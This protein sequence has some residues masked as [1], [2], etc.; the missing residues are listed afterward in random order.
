MASR[1]FSPAELEWL[2]RE[3]PRNPVKDTLRRFNQAFGR[4]LKQG[5]L[6]N[7]RR[8]YGF[9]PVMTSRPYTAR[10]LAW[11][12]REYPRHPVRETLRQ[13]NE[14]FGR[15]LNYGQ[16]TDL[17]RRHGFEQP[18]RGMAI[19][20]PEEQ[21]WMREHLAS[22]PRQEIRERFAAAF[23]RTL[24]LEQLTYIARR[25]RIL[26][27]PHPGKF[28]PVPMYSERW[29][30]QRNGPVLHIKVPLDPAVQSGRKN[31]R[32][33]EYE[34]VRKAVWV[35]TRNHGPVPE[36]HVIVQLDGDPENCDIGNLEC[37]PRSVLTILN[38]PHSPVSPA[39]SRMLFESGPRKS[40]TWSAV[41]PRD[42]LWPFR[43]SP[44][45]RRRNE[46]FAFTAAG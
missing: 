10:E 2:R 37:V 42:V 4:E 46:M 33:R 45:C 28:M 9:D 19:L 3:Y 34:W 6:M 38:N 30:N 7:A 22:A 5:Q 11:L 15:D 43:D 32:R 41:A 44:R 39:M 17:K 18:P 20:S 35:W 12:R 8:R 36:D 25:L 27:A 31:G 29:M 21:D 1:L 23:G 24:S 16:I 13:F 26:G 40:G 14:S